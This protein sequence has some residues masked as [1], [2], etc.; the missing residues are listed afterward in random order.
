MALWVVDPSLSLSTNTL[1]LDPP[2]TVSSAALTLRRET[3]WKVVGPINEGAC[4]GTVAWVFHSNKFTF[5]LSA[6]SR[7]SSKSGERPQEDRRE[8]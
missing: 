1:V 5:R 7:F 8:F 2:D 6:G 4:T 3:S